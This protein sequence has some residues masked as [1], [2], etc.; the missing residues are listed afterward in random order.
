MGDVHEIFSLWDT[1]GNDQINT[2]NFASALRSC[3]LA[4][5]D[6]DLALITQEVDEGGVVPFSKFK[7][8]VEKYKNLG[9]GTE[10]IAL[11][12]F[13]VFDR[14]DDGTATAQEMRHVISSLG[15]KLA[16]DETDAFIT[17]CAPTGADSIIQY[18]AFIKKIT[19]L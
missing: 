4:P 2:S 8:A 7:S 1:E 6:E 10:D 9:Q 14:N 12:A 15:D 18:K 5:T 16:D 19:T 13:Q 11:A 17:D 3:G